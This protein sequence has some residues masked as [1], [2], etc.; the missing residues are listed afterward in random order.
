MSW[1]QQM[2]AVLAGH[3]DPTVDASI[4][5]YYRGSSGA[6]VWKDMAAHGSGQMVIL[7]NRPPTKEEWDAAGV[8]QRGGQDVVLKTH[9]L[10]GFIILYGGFMYRPWGHIAEM[11]QDALTLG[12]PGSLRSWK[13]NYMPPKPGR[14]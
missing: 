3:Y 5:G 6:G 9:M 8:G 10:S 7:G 4:L 13:A 1:V 12:F 14:P 11:S 2:K